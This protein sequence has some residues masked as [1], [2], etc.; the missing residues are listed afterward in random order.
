[1]LQYHTVDQQTLE[2]LRQLQQHDLFRE[3]RLVGGTSLALQIGH[4]TSIDIDLFGSIETDEIDI[5]TVLAS[6]GSVTQLKSSKNIHIYLLN[7]VKVDIVNYPYPWL[8]PAILQDGLLLADMVDIAAMKI[9]A[10]TGRG[11]KKD[12]VD[13]YFLL[14][15]MD[16][17]QILD[18]YV[19]KYKDG[20]LFMTLKSIIYFDDADK[21]EMPNMF[22]DLTWNEVK[23]TI[24]AAFAHFMKK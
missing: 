7:N 3:L 15:Q 8:Q 12:F 4:R 24:S 5:N 21:D 10:V 2:L 19:A 6:M 13:L 16:I 1:M 17:A 9:A 23:E 22:S 14:Q 20:S 18:H 11:S